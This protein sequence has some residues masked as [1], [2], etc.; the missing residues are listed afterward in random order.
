MCAVCTQNLNQFFPSL[1]NLLSYVEKDLE[2]MWGW[3]GMQQAEFCKYPII[4]LDLKVR[5]LGGCAADY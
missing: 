4:I 2:E 1:K 3:V 5:E